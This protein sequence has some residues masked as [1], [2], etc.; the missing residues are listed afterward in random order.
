MK[1]KMKRIVIFISIG[2]LALICILTRKLGD[3]DEIWNFSF[4]LNIKNGLI[5]YLD[6]NI[7]TTPFLP[8]LCSIFLKIF[9]SELI[10]MRLLCY[11]LFIS[12]TF[13][14]YKILKELKIHKNNIYFFIITILF[15]YINQI[16]IDYNYFNL[17]IILVIIYLEI[18]YSNAEIKKDIIK[19]DIVIGILIGI[20]IITKHTTGLV[21]LIISLLYNIIY[22]SNKKDL[23]IYLKDSAIKLLSCLVPITIFIIYLI[24]N[25]A[26]L[27]FINYSV[28][29][30]K[31]FNNEI[32]YLYLLLIN[33]NIITT[34]L[35]VIIPILLLYIAI[36][37]IKNKYGKEDINSRYNYI[38]FC[39]SIVSLVVIFPICDDTHFYIS[40]LPSLILIFNYFYREYNPI[41]Q[42]IVN[43]FCILLCVLISI[44]IY[45]QVYRTSISTLNHY[46]YIVSD[47]ELILQIED[48]DKYI[49]NNNDKNVYIL[50]G[51]ASI[52]M[53]PINKYNKDMDICLKGNL[54]K[55]RCRKNSK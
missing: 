39:Y 23:F 38:M 55:K 17:L 2:I 10:I 29:G 13:V 24:C 26:L 49:L 53:L 28:L 47:K 36:N 20:S 9:G 12:I 3:L 22:I 32:S 42:K 52:Y 43:V 27:E 44:C 1:E 40:I 30:I 21:L 50:D 7:I 54:G 5:P 33:K 8:F 31:E 45:E 16:R 4:A 41:K 46:N 25:N 11:I 6:F 18:K 14:T 48:V 34:V 15:F 37:I 19:K 51:T 35:S